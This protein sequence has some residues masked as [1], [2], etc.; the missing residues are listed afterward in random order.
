MHQKQTGIVQCG[1][2]LQKPINSADHQAGSGLTSTGIREWNGMQPCQCLCQ[3]RVK[4]ELTG[5]R[6]KRKDTKQNIQ[7]REA[8]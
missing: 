1:L 6:E 3:G 7:A 5:V 4:R 2:K 8:L